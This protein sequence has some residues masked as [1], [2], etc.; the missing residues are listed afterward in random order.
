MGAS[1]AHKIHFIDLEAQ[2]N[3]IALDINQRIAK[4]LNRGDFIMGLEV[5]ELEDK[6]A[7]WVG[8][9]RCLTCANGTDALQIALMAYGVGP[10]DAIFVPSFTFIATAEIISLLGA[11]PIFVDSE[12]DTFNLSTTNLKQLISNFKK[13]WPQLNPR[14]IIPVDLFGQPADY[15]AINEIAR[16]HGMFVLEDAAQSFGSTYKGHRSCGITGIAT[17]SFFPAKPLGCYGDG[18]AIFCDDQELTNI[19]DSI[20]VHG[21]GVHKYESIRIGV[22]SRLDTIQAAILL[23][24]FSILE[25]EIVKRNKVASIYT[26]R[27]SK[28]VTTPI[29]RNDRTSVW[30]QYSILHDDRDSLISHLK[31]AGIPTAIYYA[32]PLHLQP[33]FAALGYKPGDLPICESVS[34]RIVSLPMH[35]Y[36]TIEIQNQIID[37]IIGGIN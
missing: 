3:R 34:R 12:E 7:T 20:R 5:A 22:N 8:S 2:R 17:T 1:P 35:P 32:T 14:G 26:E 23:S 37:G 33:A 24:K 15:D 18:G 9:R 19:I 27:L 30:A 36:L 16:D 31:A 28:Y 6:L 11:T 13:R 21:K 25:D 10:G 4:V 29:V